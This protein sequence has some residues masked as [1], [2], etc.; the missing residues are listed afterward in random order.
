M[1]VGEVVEFGG[2]HGAGIEGADEEVC[3]MGGTWVG[4]NV[5][6]EKQ[7]SGE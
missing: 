6:T 4:L 2:E 1:V 5:L 3:G 7:G